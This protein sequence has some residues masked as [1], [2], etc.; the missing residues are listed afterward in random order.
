MNQSDSEMNES[1]GRL[2]FLDPHWNSMRATPPWKALIKGCYVVVKPDEREGKK[3][4][5]D[6]IVTYQRISPLLIGICTSW[7]DDNKDGGG[8]G[9]GHVTGGT[10]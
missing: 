7:T 3:L 6:I 10:I 8:G 4:G 9:W 2:A 1:L 5:L